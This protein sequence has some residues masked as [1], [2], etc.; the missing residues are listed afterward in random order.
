ME[1]EEQGSIQE[2]LSAHEYEVPIVLIL[3]DLV[4]GLTFA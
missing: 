4:A 2:N 3:I 1:S